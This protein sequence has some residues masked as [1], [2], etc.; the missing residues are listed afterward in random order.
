MTAQFLH[1]EVQL[2]QVSVRTKY[3]NLLEIKAVNQE[4][5]GE[6][7]KDMKEQCPDEHHICMRADTILFFPNKCR[8]AN[9]SEGVCKD[10]KIFSVIPYIVAEISAASSL[11]LFLSVSIP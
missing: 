11:S 5:I 6:N 1:L 4:S 8:H 9:A 2:S 7:E 10:A 3:F